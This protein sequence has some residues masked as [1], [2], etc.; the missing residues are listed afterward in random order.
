[1]ATAFVSWS[2]L[3]GPTVSFFSPVYTSAPTPLGFICAQHSCEAPLCESLTVGRRAHHKHLD[4]GRD[5]VADDGGGG[6][7]GIAQ[8]IGEGTF[9]EGCWDRRSVELWCNLGYVCVCGGR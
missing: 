5:H 8:R 9:A 6:A 4:R 7:L 3:A 1:M 2:Y